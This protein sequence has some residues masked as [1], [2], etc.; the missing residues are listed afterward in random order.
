[1]LR[2]PKSDVSDLVRRRLQEALADASDRGIQQLKLD[3]SFVE[4]ILSSMEQQY[5]EYVVLKT[6]FDSMKV[7]IFGIVRS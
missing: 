4:A 7:S 5:Q 1:V 2:P 3:I 6:K